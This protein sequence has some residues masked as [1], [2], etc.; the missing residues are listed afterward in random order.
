MNF[1][2]AEDSVPVRR[3]IRRVATNA[4]DCVYEC[5]DGA[6]AVAA[7]LKHKFDWVL[8]DIKMPEMD[9][10]AA[11]RKICDADPQAKIIVVTTYDD[12]VLRMEAED[13]GASAFIVKD[14]L[15]RIRLVINGQ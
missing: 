8:I 1:L 3:M 10:I 12:P 15:S 5:A 7:Y 9:G 6:E 2:I 11:T 4:G 13:A 14:D